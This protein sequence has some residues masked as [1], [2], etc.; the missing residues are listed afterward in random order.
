MEHATVES[1]RLTLEMLDFQTCVKKIKKIITKQRITC[2]LGKDQKLLNDCGLPGYIVIGIHRQ[3][4]LLLPGIK[5][6]QATC[7]QNRYDNVDI[8]NHFITSAR[9]VLWSRADSVI[10]IGN[11]L[12]SQM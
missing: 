2:V 10:S 11:D 9:F 6:H 3:R 1:K 7:I 5:P 4:L 8:T 12:T